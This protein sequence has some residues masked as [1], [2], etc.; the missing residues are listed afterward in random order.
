MGS[1]HMDRIA[2]VKELETTIEASEKKI[3][4]IQKQCKHSRI[5][6]IEK[7]DA[8]CG[9]GISDRCLECD[10]VLIT[11][12]CPIYDGLSLKPVRKVIKNPNR[13]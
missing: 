3:A 13:R 4:E 2:E 11:A 6:H 5:L 8:Y 1:I 10:K 7:P 9:W 12:S